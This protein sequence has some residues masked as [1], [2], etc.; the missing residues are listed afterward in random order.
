VEEQIFINCVPEDLSHAEEIKRRLEIAGLLYY[1]PPVKLNPAL[2]VDMVEKIRGIAVRHGCMICILSQNALSNSIF[3]SNI[4]LMC[5]TA[6]NNR[7]LVFYQ[8]E[9]LESDQN[10]RLF[11]SQAYQVKNSAHTSE[12]VSMVIKR[13]NQILQPPTR[14]V[15]QILSRIVSRKALTRLLVTVAVLAV[16]ASVL[17]NFS[18]KAPPAPVLPTPTPVVIYAPFSGQSQNAGLAVDTSKVP[19]FKPDTDP[20]VA[21]PFAFQP[22]YV[23]MQDNFN[24]PAFDHSYDGQKWALNY[25]QLESVPGMAI[26]QANGVLQLAVAPTGE[27]RAYLI[28]NS[29]YMFNPQQVTYL[30]Y[31]FRL[32]DYQGKIKEN[33]SVNGGFTYQYDDIPDI[34]NLQF[35][36]LSQKMFINNTEIALGSHW[37][38]LEMVSQKDKKLIDVYLDGTKINTLSLDEGQFD[39]W[40]HA[41]FAIGVSGTTDWVSLQIDDVI[42]GGDGPG[43]PAL[44]PEDAAYRF[45]PDTIDLHEDFSTPLPQQVLRNGSE[46]VTQSG[47]AL[48]FRFP[49]GQDDQVINLEFPTKPINENNYYAM[50]FRFTSPD[51]NY[52]AAWERIFLGITNQ[53]QFSWN[54]LNWQY[55]LNTEAIRH[56]YTFSGTGLPSYPFGQNRSLGSW[57][58]IEM[59]FKPPDGNSPAYTAFF[60]VDGYLMGKGSLNQESAVLSQGNSSLGALIQIESGNYRQEVFSGE[61]DDLVIGTIASDKIKE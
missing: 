18:Q 7:V 33:T 15:Y 60:W 42:F 40:M 59:I 35:D 37:H 30:G 49:A 38:T 36:G 34:P 46:F 23:Y 10:V 11:T 47:G 51:D 45:T 57:H 50:R 26:N 5:E 53:D 41:N 21:A 22:A 54:N 24:D 13:I 17:F 29:K 28:F 16:I 4:Q 2:Q 44:R 9:Q 43:A 12:D 55:F 8:V 32:N 39:R 27:Q 6:R 14:N 58:T 1:T 31:R 3:I 25:N 20:A 52:W 61:I 19:D 48:A 56:E